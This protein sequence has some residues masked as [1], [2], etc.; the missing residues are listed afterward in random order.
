MRIERPLEHPLRA[1]LEIAETS[2]RAGHLAT[3]DLWC[4]ESRWSVR[5]ALRRMDDVD[6]DAA[7]VRDQPI[8]RYVVKQELGEAPGGL[9]E[10]F[11]HPIDPRRL[12]TSD[13]GLVDALDA[14][15]TPG[16]LFVLERD[17]VVGIITPS[18]LQRVPVAMLVLSII[19]AAEVGMNRIIAASH[20]E[21]E[22]V[23]LLPMER[24]RDLDRQYQ[25][26]I[27]RRT[28]TSLLDLLTLRDRLRL[29]GLAPQGIPILGFESLA[30]LESW[31]QRLADIRNDLAHGRTL[32][33]AEPDPLEALGLVRAIRSF[34]ERIWDAVEIVR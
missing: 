7:P 12:L 29:V 34:A 6:F 33:D 25:K 9:V 16:F 31:S 15:A 1:I 17:G 11:A 32:L 5:E 13:L 26:R 24:R 27:Q 14:L 23:N 30:D 22:W 18:D 19:L 21:N 28:Q 4:V 3:R 20:S 2:L 10:D 8:R